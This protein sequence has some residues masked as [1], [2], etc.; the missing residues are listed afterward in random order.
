MHYAKDA[1][2][3]RKTLLLPKD[4]FNVKDACLM[5]K[6]RVLRERDACAS[7]NTHAIKK[8]AFRERRVRY[9][10]ET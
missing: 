5:R 2:I 4:A 8:D 9:A 7:R 3:S 6:P 10:K 1:C